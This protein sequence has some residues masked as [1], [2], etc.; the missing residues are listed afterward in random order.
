MKQRGFISLPITAWAAIGA[1][2]LIAGLSVALKIQS[3]R[4]EACNA[5]YESFVAQTRILGEQ[6]KA[7]KEKK[8]AQDAKRVNDAVASRDDAL[9]RLRDERSRSSRVPLTPAAPAGSEQICFG[10][11]ALAAAVEQYR[12]RVRGL[13]EAGDEAQIDA[14]ALLRAWPEVGK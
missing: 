1:G 8:E 11:S 6:A 13:V 3:S 7:A 12:E 5:K 10:Q 9:R 14:Q 4:L 2:I